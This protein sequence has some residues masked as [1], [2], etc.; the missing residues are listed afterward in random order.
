[1]SP[2]NPSKSFLSHFQLSQWNHLNHGIKKGAFWKRQIRSREM[3]MAV[4]NPDFA[5][6][7]NHN[8]K[9]CF[10]CLTNFYTKNFIKWW[11]KSKISA[12][13]TKEGDVLENGQL[14]SRQLKM[15]AQIFYRSTFTER[16]WNNIWRERINFYPMSPNVLYQDP[17]LSKCG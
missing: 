15:Y 6:I 12:K 4:N 7:A 14:T 9:F 11:H 8:W 16:I 13:R 17:D 1:M 10:N 5:K 2:E 3:K